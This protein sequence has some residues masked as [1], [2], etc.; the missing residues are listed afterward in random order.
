MDPLA[1]R[2]V[3]QLKKALHGT[4]RAALLF[5]E[6]VIQAMVN[7]GFTAVRVAAQTFLNH[8]AWEVLAT[9]HGDDFTAAGESLSLDILHEASAQFSVLQKMPRIGLPE[10]GGIGEGQLTKRTMGWSADGFH[11]KAD[12]THG[13][14]VVRHCFLD[15]R[16][17]TRRLMSPGSNHVGKS[18]RDTA[19]ELVG[20]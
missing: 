16:D 18:A 8:A 13:E 2:V 1:G 20:E 11:R 3:W 4:R 12:S 5:Q 17:A 10:F 15:K 19:E 9:L 14:K 7:I 6:Y